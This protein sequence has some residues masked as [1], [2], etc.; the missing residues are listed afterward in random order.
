VEAINNLK[1]TEKVKEKIWTLQI[2]PKK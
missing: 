2:N 1:K